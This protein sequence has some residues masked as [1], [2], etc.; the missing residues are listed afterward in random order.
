MVALA[1]LGLGLLV[2]GCGSSAPSATTT[3]IAAGQVPKAELPTGGPGGKGGV[4]ATAATIP[5]A[6]QNP[7]TTLFTLHRLFQSCLKGLGVT[8]IGAPD[9][10]NPSSRT[11]NPAYIKSLTT[12]AAQ[13]N[14]CRP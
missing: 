10:S 8:F 11:N 2:A 7:T 12:C 5:L 13:S 1:G 6:K 4:N 14:I 3:Y 9:P